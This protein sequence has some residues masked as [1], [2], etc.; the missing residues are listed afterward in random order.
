MVSKAPGKW[1]VLAGD[2]DFSRGRL[3][4]NF[5]RDRR[6]PI[7][8]RNRDGIFDLHHLVVAAG[9]LHAFHRLAENLFATLP[10]RDEGL[11]GFFRRK[12]YLGGQEFKRLGSFTLDNDRQEHNRSENDSL[13]NGII[14]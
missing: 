4:A 12:T 1:L 11:A 2:G 14:H 3:I 7:A 13:E 6:L 8:D 5:R 10:L 9:K